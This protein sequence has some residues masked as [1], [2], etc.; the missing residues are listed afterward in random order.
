[1]PDQHCVDLDLAVAAVGPVAW[2]AAREMLCAALPLVAGAP[3][4]SQRPQH[5]RSMI[6]RSILKAALLAFVSAF[7]WLCFQGHARP[8]D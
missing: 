6:S 2:I 8:T 3:M 5:L 1:L 4:Q 7:F